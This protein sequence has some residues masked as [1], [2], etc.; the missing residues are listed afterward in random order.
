MKKICN[1]I[2]INVKQHK[3]F[4]ILTLVSLLFV[5]IGYEYYFKY[6]YMVRN[7]NILK[8]VILSYGN[9]SVLVFILM[10]IFQVVI[11][12]IPGEF[13]QV[14]GGYIFGALPGAVISLVGITFGSIIVYLI[15]N[16]YGKPYVEKIMMKK[17]IKFFR[18]ILTV[19]SKKSVVFIFYLIPGIPKDA[20]AY[21]CG[22]SDI[23]F[24]DFIIYSTLGRIPAIVI[25]SYFGQ[26]IYA[27]DYT[28]L[29]T[30]GVTMSIIF[31]LGI[32]KGNSIIHN[33]IKKK[34]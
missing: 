31:A 34:K 4:I 21:I 16:S 15:A 25:S 5:Y 26:E 29:I 9:F 17:K 8:E 1:S 28:T 23:S 14:A 2:R 18:K 11:F 27:Q 7:P 20:L 19:G 13:I 12:F 10:Q 33:I 6:S 24:K 30:I 3:Q 32:F 22:I